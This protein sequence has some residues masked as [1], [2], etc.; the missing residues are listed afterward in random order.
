MDSIMF[1]A[2]F[3]G[4]ELEASKKIFVFH[5]DSISSPSTPNRKYN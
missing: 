1:R 5:R 3:D 2:I 4:A